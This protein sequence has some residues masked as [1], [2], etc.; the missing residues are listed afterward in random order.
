MI[1]AA[2][3]AERFGTP[4][5]LALLNGRP[6]LQHVLDA[7]AQSRVG[8]IVLVLGASADAMRAGVTLPPGTTVVVND[9]FATGQSSSLRVGL[10]ALPADVR[11][12]VILLADEPLVDPDAIRAVATASGGPILRCS[13]AGRP[14]HPIALDRSIWDQLGGEADEGARA[15]IA[16]SPELVT[17]VPVSGSPPRDVDTPADLE[18]LHAS[19]EG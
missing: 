19:D 4:K 14:G 13:Y 12:A 11:R 9:A 16:R 5:Q 10:A 1:L 18:S 7:A 17:D 6:L 8:P 3:S 15:L 2:G